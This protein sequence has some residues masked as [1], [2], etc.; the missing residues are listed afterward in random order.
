MPNCGFCGDRI[1]TAAGLTRHMQRK[2]ECHQK[3][4]ARM[5][6]YNIH[7]ADLIEA[8]SDSNNN[9]PSHSPSPTTPDFPNPDNFI[10]PAPTPV[11]IPSPSP[12]PIE[13]RHPHKAYIEDA[14]DE[15][16]NPYGTHYVIPFPNP[17]GVRI[18]EEATSFERIARE[19]KKSGGH[20]WGEFANEDE[21]ELAEFL[22]KTVGQ[23]QTD[24]FLKLPI[25]SQR[26]HLSYKNIHSFLQKIDSIPTQCTPWI[27]QVITVAGDK[28]HDDDEVMSE[29]VELWRRDPVEC[30]Q[31]LIGNPMFCDHLAYA[32]E[33]VTGG[34]KFRQVS[35]SVILDSHCIDK[36][37]QHLLPHG[38]TVAPVI[39]ASDK[40]RLTMF[41]GDKSAWPVYLSIGNIEK[42][43]HRKV[44][45]HTMILIG[46]IPIVKLDCVSEH[47]CSI[48]GYRLFHYCMH[49]LL[50]PLIAA[51][52]DGVE[53]VCAD[54]WVRKVFP[55]LTAYIADHP[56]RCLISCCHKNWCP[57]CKENPDH[58]GDLWNELFY[59][60]SAVTAKI[61]EHHATGR[62]VPEFK[63]QGLRS[64][65]KPFWVDLPHCDIFTCIT[66]DLLHQLH[67]GMF[68][69]HLVKWC[70]AV[71]G[72]DEVDER[73]CCMTSFPGLHQFD[74]GISTVSQWT[75][76]E[77][78]EMERV[79]T[80][81]LGGGAQEAVVKTARAILDFIY[82]ASF[83][84]HT[85]DSLAGLDS[86]L[87]DFHTYKEVFTR[88]KI[89]QDF[90]FPKLH[91]MQHY[92]DAIKSRGSADGYNTELPEQLHIDF[93]K[94]AYRASNKRHYVPQMTQWLHRQESVHHFS[95][96][97]QWRGVCRE[98][99]KKTK[100]DNRVDD[101]EVV[102]WESGL[103]GVTHQQ[104]P[105]HW[106][107]KRV[108]TLAKSPPHP[109]THIEKLTIDYGADQFLSA[110]TQYLHDSR[111][112]SSTDPFIQP[113]EV[114]QFDVYD[115]IHIKLPHIPVLHGERVED[116][117]HST[118][119][120]PDSPAHFDIA[121]VLSD[122]TNPNFEG[123]PLQGT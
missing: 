26:A 62:R 20:P 44:S 105:N 97:L 71:V 113:S 46:Y 117:I 92:I 67:K 34:G 6:S 75:G 63:K 102:S 49:A 25:I 43:T 85:S 36:Y 91:A 99:K 23:V 39:L 50:E 52:K 47:S 110:L 115:Q 45:S 24:K 108:L 55:I 8:D 121:L 32:P 65:G 80:G 27:H 84:T 77:F 21:W 12:L 37:Y 59:H 68:K 17:V 74:H 116:C 111:S 96:F 2:E 60:D 66:P 61:L 56:E 101:S 107:R 1:Q 7:I 83:E 18:W 19:Q 64:V 28:I 22:I 35:Q 82:F 40:T 114:D 33:L 120:T 41:K 73:F 81:V 30:I 90:N 94:E 95:A 48:A 51:G 112:S 5:K 58:C 31:E 109:N 3:W 93:A 53:M 76:S 98:V 70:M 29:E 88:L 15:G 10:P 14:E 87:R 79:F 123:K 4:I 42:D 86:A 100:V 72:N 9:G 11:P 16:D 103:E 104:A 38:A 122:Q 119:A 89:R 78:K 57:Q 106:L 54:G 118:P 13:H 69:D